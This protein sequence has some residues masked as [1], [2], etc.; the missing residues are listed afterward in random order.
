[1]GELASL[2]AAFVWACASLL[3]AS[4]GR[5]RTSPLTMNLLKCTLALAL[6]T[7]TLRYSAGH[8][9]PASLSRTALLALGAS[10]L[11]GL[12]FGD[13]AYFHALT[14]L[15]PRRTLTFSTLGPALTA[16]L[17]WPVLGE[18][19]SWPMV[20]GMA[21]TLVGVSVVTRERAAVTATTTA[22]AALDWV[23][24][25]WA[26]WGVTCQ[27]VGTVLTKLGG[28]ELL[29]L[30]ISVVRLSIGVTA[31]LL[32][33][34]ATGRLGAAAAPLQQPALRRTLVAA[35]FLG[36]Y[37]GI[38]LSMAGVRYTYAGIAATLTSTSPIFVLPLAAIFLK[39]RITPRAA[40]GAALAVA[41]VALLSLTR[42][43]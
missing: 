13:T 20:L 40:L 42:P 1:M 39:E 31:L 38:W 33:V 12:A 5:Q 35:T 10:A 2:G 41:G 8:L 29:P 37:L 30:E 17:A 7:L 22:P 19:W 34:T 9:W 36:T 15:G 6:M 43:L 27:A 21:L 3:F 24:I 28:Q 16:L 26:I 4:L 18:R 23:G 11:L 14:R 32:Y 25:R